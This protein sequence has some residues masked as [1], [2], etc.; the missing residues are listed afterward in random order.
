[1]AGEYIERGTNGY[2][3]AVQHRVIAKKNEADARVSVNFW[4]GPH[5]ETLMIPFDN[6]NVCNQ[7]DFKYRVMTLQENSIEKMSNADTSDDASDDQHKGRIYS[8]E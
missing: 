5:M 4:S 8:K 7:H 3:P 2:W 1:M 6:C